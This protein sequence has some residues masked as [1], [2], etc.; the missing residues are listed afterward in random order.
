MRRS[1]PERIAAVEK[2]LLPALTVLCF[3]VGLW[4]GAGTS[5]LTLV[6]LAACSGF[7]V[8]PLAEGYVRR[9][10][11][12]R[13]LLGDDDDLPALPHPENPYPY[14]PH[15]VERGEHVGPV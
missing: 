8:R 9:R 5:L 4:L 13:T 7:A 3:L 2:R 10:L 12:V 14:D 11:S 15:L 6:V 1:L